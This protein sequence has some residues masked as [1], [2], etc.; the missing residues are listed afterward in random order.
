MDQKTDHSQNHITH[1]GN[2]G[3]EKGNESIND[4]QQQERHDSGSTTEFDTEHL[5]FHSRGYMVEDMFMNWVS[6]NNDPVSRDSAYYYYCYRVA[7]E[8][9]E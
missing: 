4:T 6:D 7:K 3:G 5:R 1:A 8:S 9:N 2:F